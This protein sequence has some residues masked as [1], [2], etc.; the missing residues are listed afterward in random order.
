MNQRR[1]NLFILFQGL[2]AFL[3]IATGFF[4]ELCLA[5]IMRFYIGNIT[6]WMVMIVGVYGL[7]VQAG[8]FWEAR[9]APQERVR[10]LVRNCLVLHLTGAVSLTILHLS[11]AGHALLARYWGITP[12]IIIFY[13]VV[14]FLVADIGSLSGK[15]LAFLGSE[16]GVDPAKRWEDFQGLL[17]GLS[18]LIGALLFLKLSKIG[19]VWWMVL[20]L[21]CIN[22]FII[23]VFILLGYKTVRISL[24]Y[25]SLALIGL[26]ITA[27]GLFRFQDMRQLYLKDFYHNI[28]V[29]K[30]PADFLS[31]ARHYPR[32]ERFLVGRDNLDL[33]KVPEWILEEEEPVV[34]AYTQKFTR[35]PDF[36]RG[37]MLYFN[38]RFILRS[39]FEE[40]PNEYLTHIPV[41]LNGKV[42]RRV[43]L[44]DLGAGLVTRE[45]TKHP[46][47]EQIIQ[48][49]FSPS[50]TRLAQNHPLLR[51]LN[52]AAFQDP[53]VQVV[54][55]DA[56]VYLDQDRH[57]Y[58]AIYMDMPVPASYRFSRLYS[59]E[60]FR[61]V[62]AHLTQD[63]YFAFQ[64][65][66]SG[67]FM[68]FDDQGRQGWSSKNKWPV[69][70]D[71]LQDAGFHTVIPYVSA[72]EIY[73]KQAAKDLYELTE[74]PEFD[75]DANE[76][77]VEILAAEKMRSMIVQDSLR[78]YVY[79]LQEGFIFAKAARKEKT[80]GY[81]DWVGD[82][83]VLNPQRF[84]AAFQFDYPQR[85]GFV[86]RRINT[87]LRPYLPGRILWDL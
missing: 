27:A 55:G 67:H 57:Y 5:A 81:R 54:V 39:D 44:F 22:I 10:H 59:S 17:L 86:S 31:A 35:Q 63:G 79:A 34:R 52:G 2:L 33:V 23:F 60:F 76:D 16:P 46:G 56:F 83:F 73:H 38:G 37:Y 21:A 8:S 43:L 32:I 51:Y 77:I 28:L 40:I 4:Y 50:L 14:F 11:Y 7:S 20:I 48:V 64:A 58:D 24:G 25:G 68:Y 6:L 61:R 9:F 18:G 71:T 47:I 75:L 84:E 65:P 49:S 13:S 78:K 3:A 80:P 66:G 1:T 42:P 87:L 69:Y 45:L 70:Y 29:Y 82:L 26:L 62:R 12:A 19:D 74:S 15:A 36:P 30:G 85:A 53:R 41:V 72:F